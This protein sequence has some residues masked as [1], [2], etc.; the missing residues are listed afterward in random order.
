MKAEFVKAKNI[1]NRMKRY[2]GEI[3]MMIDNFSR[4][5]CYVLRE[6]VSRARMNQ[7]CQLITSGSMNKLKDIPV[8]LKNNDIKNRLV[9]NEVVPN[10]NSKLKITIIKNKDYAYF[11]NILAFQNNLLSKNDHHHSNYYPLLGRK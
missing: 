5:G 3:L 9:V 6:D 8:D 1:F 4:N 7:L 11:N 2:F 10:F